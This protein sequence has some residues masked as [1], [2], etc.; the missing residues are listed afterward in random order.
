MKLLRYLPRFRQAYSELETMA[1]R[2][3]WS[4]SDLDAFQLERLNSVWGRSIQNVPYY[5]QLA[6]ERRLPQVFS[7]LT[8]FQTLVPILP[9]SLVQAHP[10]R[11]LSSQPAPG[12][13]HRT[14]GS[15]GT[16]LS[17]YW[18]H[19]AHLEM[20]R[21]KYR[22]Y[23]AW[24]VDFLDRAAFLWGHSASFIP[25]WKG[26]VA[27]LRMPIED[28]LRGRLR[29]SAYR[30]GPDDLRGYLRLISRF[31][32]TAIYGYSTALD[33]LARE[34]E[35]IHFACDSLKL[36]TLTAEPALAHHVERIERV[37]GVPAVIEYGAVECGQ[38]A[39]E[40]PDRTLRVRDD[41]VFLETV[42]RED[43]RLDILVTILNNTSFPLLRYTINDVT[44][45][46][47]ERP[48][49]GF[50][51]LRNVAGRNND[52]IVGRSGRV[53][54]S[55][56]FDA[57]FKYEFKQIRRFRL[58]QRADGAVALML[59]VDPEGES[60]DTVRVERAVREELEGFPVRIEVTN[61]I[62]QTAA[63]KHRAVVSDLAERLNSASA[64]DAPGRPTTGSS[65]GNGRYSNGSR[66][67]HGHPEVPVSGAPEPAALKNGSAAPASQL[68]TPHLP[69]SKAAQLRALIERPE[70]SFL[71]EAHN[72][73]SAKIAE[74]AGFEGLW[75]SGLSI[76]ASLGVRDSNEASWTQVLEIL[77]FMNDA[78]RLPILVDGDT[79]Y[80]NFN[81]MRRL[82]QKL[83]QRGIAGV[84]IEDK[85]FPK[86]NS[87]LHG[88]AQQLADIDEFSGRISAGKDAQQSRDFVIVARVEA[89]IA[90]WGLQEALKRAE[91]YHRAG[92]DAIL[93]HSALRTADEVLAFKQAWGQRLPVVIVPTKYYSTPMEVFREHGFATVIWANHLM[94]SCITAMQRTANA[95]FEEQSPV[96]VEDRIATLAEVFRIQGAAELE[97]AEK[98]YLPKNASLT[99]AIVLA[100]S[101]GE[102]LGD[103]TLNRPKCMVQIAGKPIL[104][105][106]VDAYRATGIRDIC[107]VRGYRKETV[108]VAGVTYVDTDP[109]HATN[110][111]TNLFAALGSLEGHCVISYG[112]VLFKKHV[113]Q[114]LLDTEGDFVVLVDSN[115]EQT[116][117]RHRS[118]DL[119]QCTEPHSRHSFLKS[120]QLQAISN[121]LPDGAIH[122][123]WM[124]F[125]KVSDRGAAF[126][127]QLLSELSQ[128]HSGWDSLTM[129][130]LLTA[131]LQRGKTIQVTYTTGNWLDVDSVDDVLT[132]GA[133]S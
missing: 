31:R 67:N 131:I 40:W 94:R 98:R 42:P 79:G 83:E 95:L 87:F 104:G 99:R 60:L 111:A 35:R 54:H 126:L 75:A 66:R 25:G 44:D 38:L 45:A 105:H 86:T 84:C 108:D 43:D 28:R 93:I 88:T 110:R 37:F 69:R 89:F 81:N 5:R 30:I 101:R 18:E 97:E 102:A 120:I 76:S 74:E 82:V 70:L 4:R 59:D 33:L 64:L 128:T 51:I 112:D 100:P 6:S 22:A 113:L 52:M 72:G 77:E 107:V 46:P 124:G 119:V 3:T 17:A 65:N 121:D 8:E 26:R 114:E 13:W 123:E 90:G 53:M 11:F 34:A 27:R 71:M 7:S 10:E 127:C 9:R 21:V 57:M 29:L 109:T 73:L 16:P 106:I 118:A 15:T 96:P 55:A 61:N 63:G 92:A 24:G 20:L 91:A 130:D 49:R 1:A 85:I 125:L 56:R 116:A 14:G 12:K 129:G 32:P 122:G 78:T 36:F 62:P 103:L 47:L 115:W 19:A 23:Q 48:E 133:F 132:G 50:A 68:E 58:R 39:N 117:N 41:V 2:E 80:G